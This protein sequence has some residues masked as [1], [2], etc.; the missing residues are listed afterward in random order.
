MH[1]SNISGK[2]TLPKIGSVLLTGCTLLLAPD[3]LQAQQAKAWQWAGTG[4]GI[5]V[6]SACSKPAVDQLENVYIIG[7]FRSSSEAMKFNNST[8]SLTGFNPGIFTLFMAKYDKNGNFIWAKSFKSG[9]AD[10]EK[11]GIDHNGNIYCT[12]LYRD[13]IKIDNITLSGS[14]T[15]YTQFLAKFSADGNLVWAKNITSAA[16]GYFMEYGA[17][18]VTPQG[19]LF[20][21]GNFNQPSLL[22]G[23]N[24]VNNS[25]ST[26]T[27]FD[28]FAVEFN[29]A[30]DP[31]WARAAG[32]ADQQEFVPA[33]CANAEGELYMGSMHQ[34]TGVVSIGSQI[35]IYKYDANGNLI[36][37][38]AING[39]KGVL[40]GAMTNDSKGNLYVSGTY[41]D[42][43][44]LDN[45]MLHEEGGGCF[46]AKYSPQGNVTW[47]KSGVGSETDVSIFCSGIG[48]DLSGTVSISGS[49]V[50][51]LLSTVT[52]ITFDTI[53][54]TLNGPRDAFLTQY[55]KDG[56]VIRAIN[57]GGT[58]SEYNSGLKVLPNG[59]IYYT[60]SFY[61]PVV[62]LDSVTLT[63]TPNAI[64]NYYGKFFV[65]KYSEGS[66]T[67][68]GNINNDIKVALYPNPSTGIFTIDVSE[69]LKALRVVD[70]A[71]RQL[72][73]KSFPGNVQQ[74]RLDLSHFA[75]GQYYISIYTDKGFVIKPVTL[76]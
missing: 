42:T 27:S 73:H 69:G 60:G 10:N 66:T 45:T 46:T 64:G 48:V 37:N 35:K 5:E 28:A 1:T 44:H 74:Q 52:Q 4:A 61:S 39:N 33:I 7:S 18:E 63:N 13:S 40:L 65:A 54:L 8:V 58:Q 30:G 55:D 22:F 20:L 12:A 21:A 50:Y 36:G 38:E 72:Y 19:R 31:V 2:R 16:N 29:A 24:T 32:T 43:A 17:L 47:A 14:S 70:L 75:K 23:N 3:A 26:G 34:D 76:K 53:T 62:A 56:N 11:I 25:N 49:Y 15:Q 6:S 41:G 59:N 51:S 57:I 9:T 67:G 71:G 68:I